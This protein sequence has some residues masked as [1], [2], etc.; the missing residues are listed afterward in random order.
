MLM[1]SFNRQ[2]KGSETTIC[3]SQEAEQVDIIGNPHT[4][5]NTKIVQ[6]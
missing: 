4:N 6:I 2:V 1:K 3:I 5:F